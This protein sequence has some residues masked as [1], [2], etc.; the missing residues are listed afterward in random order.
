[1]KPLLLVFL[2]GG[3]GSILR[4]VISKTL[5]PYFQYFFLGTFLVNIIGCLLI[6]IILGLSFRGNFLS[7]NQTLLLTTG[8]CGGFTTFSTFAFEKHSLLT[9][10]ELLYFSVYLLVSIVVGIAA[11]AFGLWLSKVL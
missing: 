3:L 7:H 9:A 5:N 2:G 6:G 10:G 1:V 4:Y 8:F 11:V